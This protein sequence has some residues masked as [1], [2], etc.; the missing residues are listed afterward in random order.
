MKAYPIT[1]ISG[2]GIGKEVVPEGVRVFEAAARRFGFSPTH[3]IGFGRLLPTIIDPTEGSGS[4]EK[5][6]LLGPIQPH[7][8]VNRG[9]YRYLD[10]SVLHKKS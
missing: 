8:R 9:K 6:M 3:P 4:K 7:V 2:D 1:V 10:A 5:S